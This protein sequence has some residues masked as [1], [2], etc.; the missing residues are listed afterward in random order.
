[1]KAVRVVDGAVALVDVE[2]PEPHHH[3]GSVAPVRAA[4]ICGT[5][6]GLVTANMGGFTLG[7][8]MVVA[9]DGVPYAVEPTIR[10]GECEQCRTG[11]TQRCTGEHGNL[12][13]FS[14]GGLAERVA[15][16]QYALVPLP[17][18]L[19]P[20][21]ACLVEPAAVA[22]H[23]VRRAAVEPGA[24]VAVV[25]GGSIG[26]LVVAGLRSL[27]HQ[28]DLEA[29]H[30]HQQAAG[31]RLGAGAVTRSD[32]YDVVIDAAGSPSALERCAALARPGARMVLLGVYYDTV[33]LPGVPLLVKELTCVGAMAYGRNG[34]TREV[35]E[36]A[37]LLASD[38]A[39]AATLVTHRFALSEAPEAFRVAGDRAAGAIKVVLEAE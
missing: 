36:A 2:E 9:V 23:G 1:M 33:P 31:G 13:I 7:H 27:G 19:A 37:A 15:V 24:S 26:L 25:G 5:D 34:E 39:I 12:G 21:D 38:P 28:V 30:A 29:R 10:C 3:G 16:P 8:E 4:S 18:G 6:L 22:W 35:E 20:R 17:H 14:D 32:H 11:A